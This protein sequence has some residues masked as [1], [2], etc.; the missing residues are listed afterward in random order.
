MTTTPARMAPAASTSA[1]TRWLSGVTAALNPSQ[2][3]A[4]GRQLPPAD[5]LAFYAALA[6]VGI[7]E[8]VEWPAVLIAA[9]AQVLLDRASAHSRPGLPHLLPRQPHRSL[10]KQPAREA[11]VT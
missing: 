11:G 10:A 3:P 2:L 9:G 4:V 8:I 6:V 7:I 1:P 5:S